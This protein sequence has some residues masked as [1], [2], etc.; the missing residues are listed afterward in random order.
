VNVSRSVDIAARILA[1]QATT[2]RL[3]AAGDQLVAAYRQTR[4]QRDRLLEA[5]REA[6][7][8]LGAVEHAGA[9]YVDEPAADAQA[10]VERVHRLVLEAIAA[11]E[12]RS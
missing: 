12:V 10:E 1:G 6:E 9:E 8:L 4:K 11:A 2:Q 5:L 7:V 3:Q